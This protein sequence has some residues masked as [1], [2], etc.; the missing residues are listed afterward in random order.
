MGVTVSSSHVVSAA[1]S[2]SGEGLLTLFPCSSVR[3][4]SQETVLHK[5]LQHESFPQ[6][7]ALH[8]LPQR[9]SFPWGAVLQ[10]QAASAWVP[11]GVTYSTSKSAPAWVSLSSRVHRLWQ[12]PAPVRAPHGVA[13]SFRHTSGPAWGLF[14]RLQVEIC[15]TVD[16]HGLQGASLPQHGLHSGMQGKKIC[17]SIWSTS[18]PSFFTDLGVCRVVSFTSSHSS[19]L[20]ATSPQFFSPS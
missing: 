18:S 9:G 19:L 7:A 2:S 12:E 11:H 3:S 6:A 1:P 13:A 15:S 17:F 5:L 14:L 8:E 16:F 20:T 10:E 4:L